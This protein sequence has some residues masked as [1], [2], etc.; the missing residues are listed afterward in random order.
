MKLS[1]REQRERREEKWWPLKCKQ[2]ESDEDCNSKALAYQDDAPAGQWMTHLTRTKQIDPFVRIDE[3]GHSGKSSATS[4]WQTREK[5]T[6]KR[7]TTATLLGSCIWPLSPEA[8]PLDESTF[9]AHFPQL[10]RNWNIMLLKWRSNFNWSI[11]L[12]HVNVNAS[13]REYYWCCKNICQ[14]LFPIKLPFIKILK[15]N[16]FFI[17]K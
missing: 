3:N 9:R 6:Q 5:D 7:R 16:H 2:E 14:V 12:Y 11:F 13:F 4:M 15:N 10:N 1:D 17:F 8:H